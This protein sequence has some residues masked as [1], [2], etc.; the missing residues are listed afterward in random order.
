MS[1]F[2]AR[3]IEKDIFSSIGVAETGSSDVID[4]IG[5]SKFSCQAI[6]DVSTPSAK[7]FDSGVAEIDTFT[8]AATASTSSGDYLVCYDTAGL[9]WAA[10]ADLTGV[11]PA[12]TGAVWVAIPSARKVQVNLL[13]AITASNVATAFADALTALTAVPFASVASTTHVACTQGT[14]GAITA[15]AVHNADDSG[16]GSITKAVTAAGVNSEVDVTANTLAIPND[17][18]PIGFKVRATTTGTLPAPLALLT[19]YFIIPVDADTIQLATSLANA[20]AGIPINITNQGSSGA[21]NTLTGVALAGATLTF[22]KS[23]NGTDWIN[24]QSATSITV[25]TTVAIQQ[26]DVSYRY[27]KAVKA[28]TAGSVDIKAYVLVIGDAV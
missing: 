12:P 28:L 24:I 23:N 6:I 7:T 1:Q 19:D 26:T 13:T 17:G 20:E 2:N 25:D 14:R 8:F 4:L 16:A 9:A 27:F 22:Q 5:A 10:A 11:D 18:F 21:V 3:L 15:P